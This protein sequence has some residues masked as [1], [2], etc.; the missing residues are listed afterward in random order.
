MNPTLNR[1]RLLAAAL[2]ASALA[3][4]S[5][6]SLAGLAAPPGGA[7]FVFV[8]LRGGL[9]GLAAAPA[10]GDPDFV[11]VRG[12]LAQFASPALAPDSTF[13]LHPAPA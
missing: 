6:L 3:S 8:I 1:R 4:W 12:P 9:D 2:G 5:T 7:R 11:A 10:V 13:A